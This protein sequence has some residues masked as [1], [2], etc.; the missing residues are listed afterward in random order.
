MPEETRQPNNETFSTPTVMKNYDPTP[1]NA[2]DYQGDVVKTGFGAVEFTNQNETSAIAAAE[3]AKAMVQARFIVAMQRPRNM[4]VVAQ[5]IFNTCKRPSFAEIAQ[6][7]KP[8]GKAMIRGPS[9]RFADEA[10][11]L[12]GNI[13][14]QSNSTYEDE[15]IRKISVEATD[16]ETNFTKSV[17]VVIDKTVER[18]NPT[19]R[20]II[21]RRTNS[22]GDIVYIVKATEDEVFVKTN[23]Q[24]AKARRNLELQLIPQDILEDAMEICSRTVNNENAKDPDLFKKQL[25]RAFANINIMP[26]ELEKYLGHSIDILSKEEIENLRAVHQ[27]IVQGEATWID[28][29][30]MK[31]EG[32]VGKRSEQAEAAREAIKAA[33]SQK[34]SRPSPSSSPG[35]TRLSQDQKLQGK[36]I[37]D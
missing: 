32:E 25:M 31:S 17:E 5:R 21:G 19:G 36:T 20:E 8:I 27:S 26:D 15:S 10:S 23:S 37:N 24:I 3:H 7:A 35:A 29:R 13:Y 1:E 22:Y 18:R 2:N 6:Y 30:D 28:F 33:R 16:L 14:V 12:M 9:V 34:S 11:K 4:N